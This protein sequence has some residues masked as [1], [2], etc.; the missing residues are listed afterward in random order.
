MKVIVLLVA[1]TGYVL[2]QVATT[3]SIVPQ[4]FFVEKIGGDKVSVNVMVLPGNSP[5]TYEPSPVQMT[6]L[7]K[8]DIYFS[9]GV[10]F[11]K[12]WLPRFES[13]AK[14][15]KFVDV[16]Q[17]IKKRVI[18]DHT[19]DHGHSDGHSH[20]HGH[21]AKDPHIWLSPKLAKMMAKNIYEALVENDGANK[22]LYSAN[23]ETFLNELDAL[24][25]QIKENLSNISSN[26]F[27]VFHPSWG[28]FAD[29]YGLEQISI[30][31]EGKEPKQRDLMRLI[32]FAKENG[33]KVVFVSPEF[34]QKSAKVIAENIGGET[35]SISP[36]S[37]KWDENLLNMSKKLSKVLD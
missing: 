22:G 25:A 19:H 11:E 27:I 5:A 20:A 34:S 3:V 7:A 23:Y 35:I 4:K 10:P 12:R 32:D 9:I 14:N 17:G 18:Q 1:L 29:D 6:D 30:E 36:L 2:A 37:L 21:A 15:T 26:K 24:D 33:V 31:I 16:S 8:A 13:V 28:Y